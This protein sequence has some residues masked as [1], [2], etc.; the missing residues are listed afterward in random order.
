VSIVGD[1]W[2]ALRQ[3]ARR[4]AG[5]HLRRIHP[6]ASCEILAGVQQPGAMSGLLLGRGSKM[7]CFG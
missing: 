3:E 2:I 1:A 4:E 7:A 6:G 5:W